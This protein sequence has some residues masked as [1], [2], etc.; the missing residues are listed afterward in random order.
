MSDP[1]IFRK[2]L[3][4]DLDSL[5]IIPCL[6]INRNTPRF[7]F[8]FKKP[9]KLNDEGE[10]QKSKVAQMRFRLNT[11]TE[12]TPEVFSTLMCIG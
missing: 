9:G 5:N 1:N 11:A 6:N 8:F 10:I 7:F 4:G 3:R 2:V 12:N